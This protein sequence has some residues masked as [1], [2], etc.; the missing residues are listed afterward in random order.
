[1]PTL[2]VFPDLLKAHVSGYT[3]SD[4]AFV[5]EHDDKRAAAAPKPVAG[6]S[7]GAGGTYVNHQPSG[8]TVAHQAAAPKPTT[9]DAVKQ[10]AVAAGAK[11]GSSVS[12][13][14]DPKN[15]HSF[16][17]K[18]VGSKGGSFVMSHPDHGHHVVVGGADAM[19][20]EKNGYKHANS[21]D[22]KPSAAT[23]KTGSAA[24][25]K[26]VNVGSAKYPMQAKSSEK[27]AAKHADGSTHHVG[28]FQ[29][30]V[31]GNGDH[32]IHHDGKAFSFTGKS[33]KNMKTGE[34]SYEYAHHGDN[35]EHR[36]WVT[37][38]GHLM[39]D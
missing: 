3:R 25:A 9:P 31:S 23:A 19:R 39:N 22:G 8:T 38:S 12:V 10:H 16:A 27:L 17:A 33:G 37:H 34:A 29:P 21:S 15:A 32:V 28:G 14:S 2:I 20:M 5:Q 35:M 11:H 26:T 6:G 7:N 36:A 1:M 4:G 13:F 18:A 30:P 24:P